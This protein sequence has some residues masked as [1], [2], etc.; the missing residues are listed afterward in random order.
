MFISCYLFK[1]IQ[2][3]SHNITNKLFGKEKSSPLPTNI[4]LSQLS[5][6]FCDFFVSKVSII[7][8]ELDRLS[9]N[10][11]SSALHCT[12]C[13]YQFSALREVSEEEV[14]KTILKAKPTTCLLDPIPTP[15][16]IEYLDQLLPTITR[17]MNDSLLSGQFPSCFKIAI[18]R[19]LLKKSNLD[20]N[21]LKNYRPV[22]NLSFLSKILEKLVL[23]QIF[24]HLN[25]NA[26]LPNNQS[27]YRANHSTESAL[28]R[29]CNDVLLALDSGNVTVLSL[30][31]LSAAFDTVDHDI[32]FGTLFS[33]FGISGSALTWF[34]SYLTNR[35]QSVIIENYHSKPQKLQFG[36]P[37]GSVLGPIL[38]L[39]YTKPLLNSIDQQHIQNQSFADDTQLYK[40]SKPSD[41]LHSIDSI[42]SCIN[43][44]RGWMTDN[45][46]KLNDDK[47]EAILFHSK[48]SFSSSTK[49][50]SL[51]VGSSSIPFAPSARN[52][53]FI[54]TQDMS[55]DAHITQTCRT[56]YAAIRQISTIR[57]YLTTS[58]TK[59]LVCAFV[60]SRLDYC[61]SLLSGSPQN[62]LKKL[63]KV[64]Y[65]AA[66]LV[67]Q[68]RKTDHITPIL[69]SLHWLPIHARIEYKIGVL[70][71]NFFSDLSPLYLSSCLT[72]YAP[73]R[74]LRSSSDD[75]ILCVP[76]TKSKFGDR[77]FSCF[78]PKFWNSLPQNIRH[79]HSTASFKS[80]LKTYLFKKYLE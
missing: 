75:R 52:L 22:S 14:R 36:V 44:V 38:F 43:G 12:Q 63:D 1:G 65:S 18:V 23:A 53:G 59:T 15:L 70:C 39:M 29:V 2:N 26:L 51:Q 25:S 45:R 54:I 5:D 61:N 78:A 69:R 37:Q 30:L 19:P 76:R 6:A 49:P 71:H 60:L 16:L 62:L 40:S 64:Q 11:S 46:L 10:V 47:T 66:R 3:P 4:P 41:V 20:R 72:V 77:S 33:Y 21:N 17:I 74:N 58:A 57:Q 42:Q 9:S 67:M 27:A 13:D 79:I 24:E 31:D 8:S 7:R 48:T 32:L 80:A 55:L 56:A 73:C 50:D 28:L 35:S 68:A 34:K